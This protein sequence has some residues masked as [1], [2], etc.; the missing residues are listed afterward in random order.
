MNGGMGEPL[1]VAID[2][3]KGFSFNWLDRPD[4]LTP[5]RL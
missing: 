4:E 5:I 2:G 1:P 3:A